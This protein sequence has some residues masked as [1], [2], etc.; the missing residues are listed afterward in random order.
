MTNQKWL[1]PA[2]DKC[3]L[4]QYIHI[5]HLLNTYGKSGS[6]VIESSIISSVVSILPLT[7]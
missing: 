4:S 7:H 6:G 5:M 1:P 3:W 2:V